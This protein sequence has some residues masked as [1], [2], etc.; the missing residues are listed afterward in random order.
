MDLSVFKK[1]DF[2]T[3][4]KIH[5]IEAMRYNKDPRRVTLVGFVG[6]RE[7]RQGPSFTHGLDSAMALYQDKG[8]IIDYQEFNN[9]RVKL[10][11]WTPTDLTD[12]MLAADG[13]LCPTHFH[14]GNLTG[15]R[16][17]W[18]MDNIN[19][20]LDRLELHPGIPCGIHTYCTSWRQDKFQEYE[21]LQH[22]NLSAPTIGI[23]LS[24]NCHL[25]PEVHKQIER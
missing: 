9:D 2:L 10:L 13:H 5:S 1:A 15:T 22:L 21:L 19:T 4:M 3:R 18:H 7:Y 23:D 25:D 11:G 6:G 17:A 14:Q 20:S 24:E 8:I 16:K 12:M